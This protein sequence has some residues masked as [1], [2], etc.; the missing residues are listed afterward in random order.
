L[1]H[2]AKWNIK[3]KYQKTPLQWAIRAGH[4]AMAYRIDQIVFSQEKQQQKTIK[5]IDNTIST[6][7]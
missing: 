4:A 5:Q 3:D 2:G 7:W 1:D 6:P